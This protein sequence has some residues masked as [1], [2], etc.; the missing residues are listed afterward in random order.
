MINWLI[1]YWFWLAIPLS[2]FWGIYGCIEEEKRIERDIKEGNFLKIN[3]EKWIF[4]GIFVS[5]FIGSFAGWICLG[6]LVSRYRT[7]GI[8]SG[9]F[10]VFLGTVAV[11]GIS[12]YSYQIASAFKK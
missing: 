5:E 8:T 6:I 1:K 11:I 12:G 7:G 2:V 10:D 4:A 9:G 3:K